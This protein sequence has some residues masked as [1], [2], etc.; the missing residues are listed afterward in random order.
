MKFFCAKATISIATAIMLEESGIGYDPVLLN[1][2]EADQLKPE[3]QAI[4]PKGRVPALVTGH[5]VL[6]ETGAILEYLNTMANADM[7]PADPWEAAQMRAVMYYL[8]STFHINHAHKKRGARWADLEASL[9]D[10]TAKVPETMGASCAY[11]EENCAL[12]PFVMGAEMT[13]ADPWLFT[14]CTWL[15]GD[16]VDITAYPKLSAHFDMM[17]ARPSV[18]AVRKLGLIP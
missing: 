5:G 8:A 4:N 17:N 3:Y 1:F 9:K 10:M 6:T 12:S 16:G 2:A 11:I 13:V 15:N 14:I 18:A 7:V